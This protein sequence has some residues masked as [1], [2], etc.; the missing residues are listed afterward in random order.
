MITRCAIDRVCAIEVEVQEALPR[1]G[2]ASIQ[3]KY[4]AGISGKGTPIAKIEAVTHSALVL[5]RARAL[6]DAI[7]DEVEGMLE[8]NKRY[9]GGDIGGVSID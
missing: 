2:L 8:V 3:I 7:A 9:S 1:Q 5:Q 6:V 4:C